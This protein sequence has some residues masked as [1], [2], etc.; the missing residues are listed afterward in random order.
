MQNIIIYTQIVISILLITLILIQRRDSDI[1]GFMGG[2]S[3]GNGGFYQQRRGL[4]Q[5]IFITTIVLVIAFTALALAS[6]FYHEPLLTA[7]ELAPALDVS[8]ETS[9]P[10]TITPTTTTP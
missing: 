7:E 5:F 2:S 4:E 3:G 8:A 6:V 10:V 1:S 9:A